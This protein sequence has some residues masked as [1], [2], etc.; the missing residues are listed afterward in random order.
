M[1][2]GDGLGPRH[3]VGLLLEALGPDVQHELL[4]ILRGQGDEDAKEEIP[5]DG[6]WALDLPVVWHVL[7]ERRECNGVGPDALEGE[8]R[9]S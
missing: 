1:G 4:H 3:P 2:D 8:L 6:L 5:L 7:P 9:P